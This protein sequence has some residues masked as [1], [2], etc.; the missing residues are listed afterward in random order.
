MQT[1]PTAGALWG[2]LSWL[3]ESGLVMLCLYAANAQK[4]GVLA[5]VLLILVAKGVVFSALSG[6]AGWMFLNGMFLVCVYF[7][8]SRIQLKSLALLASVG[9]L[10]FIPAQRWLSGRQHLR[11]AI[12]GGS[13]FAERLEIT[14]DIFLSPQLTRG[15]DQGLVSAYRDRGDYSD[16]LAAAIA[17]T[18]EV[19]PYAGGA[20]YYDVL[21]ALVPRFLWPEKPYR[22]GGSE[23]VTQYTGIRFGK[24]TSVG[25]NYLFELYV[26]FGS[27]GVVAG[28]FLFGLLLAWMEELYYRKGLDNLFFEYCLI[29]CAWNVCLYSDTMAI[30]MMTLP[31]Q[32]VVCLLIHQALRTRVTSRYLPRLWGPRSLA[33]A[34]SD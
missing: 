2:Q 21:V 32:I 6:H 11:T 33:L 34:G 17:H 31:P 10:A 9:L 1:I 28:M 24:N 20:T 23:F 7:L 26:N 13:E 27:I 8:S 18:P 16:L 29:L 14:V 25:M 19:E 30:L 4:P 22:A 15:G 5:V 12:E 3:I